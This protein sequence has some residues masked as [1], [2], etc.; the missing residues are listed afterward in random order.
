MAK[1]KKKEAI[2][3]EEVVIEKINDIKEINI[4]EEDLEVEHNQIIPI[5]KIRVVR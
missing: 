1:A 4:I 5:D 3:I 2:K